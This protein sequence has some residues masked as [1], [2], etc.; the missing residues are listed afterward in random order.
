MKVALRW[1]ARLDHAAWGAF[2]GRIDHWQ[3]PWNG[4][5]APGH[6]LW[7]QQER[8]GSAVRPCLWLTASMRSLRLAAR[9]GRART[10]QS[11]NF[12]EG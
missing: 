5:A 11:G 7:Y 2:A 4:A 6:V 10:K 1:C 8:G 3:A 12:L 9:N